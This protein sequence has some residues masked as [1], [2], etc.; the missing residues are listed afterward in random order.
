M[1]SIRRVGSGIATSRA[2]S[3]SAELEVTAPVRQQP[4]A[5]V[6]PV[7][8]GFSDESDFQADADGDLA[9]ALLADAG[10]TETPSGAPGRASALEAPEPRA[11]LLE[12]AQLRTFAGVSEFEAA[13]PSYAQRLGMPQALSSPLMQARFSNPARRAE[14]EP[15]DPSLDPSDI[16]SPDAAAWELQNLDTMP[17]TVSA[18]EAE[19][20]LFLL[21]SGDLSSLSDEQLRALSEEMDADD[22]GGASDLLDASGAHEDPNGF[23]ATLDDGGPELPLEGSMNVPPPDDFLA[24][25]NDFTLDAAPEAL[26]APQARAHEEA[27]VVVA[28]DVDA[29]DT[30]E[31]QATAQAS[32]AEPEALAHAEAP[33]EFEDVQDADLVEVDAAGTPPP[34]PS[35][36]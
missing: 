24:D 6:E 33:A 11:A 10:F 15:A 3:I 28:P 22:A 19:D 17:R 35:E 29:R 20:L 25:V 30:L 18:Q 34:P 4:M 36:S 27:R 1:T 7:R 32:P 21:E 26:E 8:R 23:M 31:A 13:A 5:P 12:N 2:W 16:L 9:G 14:A